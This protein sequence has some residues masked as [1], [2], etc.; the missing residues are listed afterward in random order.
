[1]SEAQIKNGTAPGFFTEA[2]PDVM[3]TEIHR[4]AAGNPIIK[5]ATD[6]REGRDLKLGDYGASKVVNMKREGKEAMQNMVMAS[7]QVLVGKNI[8]KDQYNARIREIRGAH[9][10]MPV[11]G[12]RLVCTA[13]DKRMGIF[14]GGLFVVEE[15]WPPKRGRSAD[16]EIKMVVK[17]L[18]I[19][20]ASSVKVRSRVECFKGGIKSL[21]FEARRGLQEFDYGYALT[22][23]KSQGSQWPSV[24][25]FNESATFKAE[26]RRWLY[27]GIT[28]AAETINIV[29]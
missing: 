23:H 10:H 22:V 14:N 27:T 9:N 29:T 13:N 7:D 3:L 26:A 21:P 24:T 19:P 1:M 6:I 18:D 11:V 28:R 8:T 15:V 25:L 12:D 17:S 16:G 2:T 20:E 5:L 4:Q